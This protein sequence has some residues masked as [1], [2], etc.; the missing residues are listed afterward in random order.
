MG[1]YKELAAAGISSD[2]IPVISSIRVAI[3]VLALLFLALFLFIMKRT[4]LGLEVRAVMQNP[5][6][7]ASMGINPTGSP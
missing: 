3:F 4:R 5:G 1:F 2:D 6:M 7:A